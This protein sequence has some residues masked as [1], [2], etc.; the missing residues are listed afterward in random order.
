MIKTQKILKS[1]KLYFQLKAG[2][3]L[4]KYQSRKI[5]EKLSFIQGI[6]GQLK[7]N[8]CYINN[9]RE[10]LYLRKKYWCNQWQ[11]R[12]A[13]ASPGHPLRQGRQENAVLPAA[14]GKARHATSPRAEVGS[15]GGKNPQ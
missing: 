13:D 7:K 15:L 6:G 8:K 1:S 3:F 12:G 9:I 4:A 2:K 10:Y 11:N 14:G 5:S